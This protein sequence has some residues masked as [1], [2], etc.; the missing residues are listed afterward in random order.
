MDAPISN[1]KRINAGALTMLFRELEYRVLSFEPF[2][3]RWDGRT[4]H[5][6]VD[7]CAMTDAEALVKLR[8]IHEEAQVLPWR[9]CGPACDTEEHQAMMRV[10]A[11]VSHGL[12]PQC[13]KQYVREVEEFKKANG[14]AG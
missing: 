9:C 4:Q 13:G 7:G 1:S 2:A 10:V 14:G 6:L 12:C 8:E 11:G 3:A 5:W